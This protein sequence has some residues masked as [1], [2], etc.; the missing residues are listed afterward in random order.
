MEKNKL[1]FKLYLINDNKSGYKTK[2][3]I[4]LKISTL[5]QVF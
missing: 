1:D 3:I 2:K 4:L 5:D